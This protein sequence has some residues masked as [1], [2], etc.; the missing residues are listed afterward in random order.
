MRHAICY[1]S[2]AV[3]GL[4]IN[5]I[6]EILDVSERNNNLK[7]IT[8]ILLFSEGNFFQ[9]LEGD[10]E[11]LDQLY[12]VIRQDKRHHSLLKI[13]QKEVEEPQFESYI[14]SFSAA[15]AT[16]KSTEVK[17]YLAEVDNLNPSVR[18]SVKYILQTFIGK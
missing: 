3:P 2:T 7:N 11:V 16:N 6:Q 17:S 9:V 10:K 5:Q 12:E 15:N 8:G 14:C 13:L 1:V 18:N 4:D